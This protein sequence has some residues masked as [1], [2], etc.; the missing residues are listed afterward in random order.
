MTDPR[1]NV[2][3]ILLEQWRGDCIGV[4]E[5]APHVIQTPNIDFIAREGIRFSRAYAE[6]PTCAPARRCII[7]GTSPAANGATGF[8]FAPWNPAHTMP[9][10]LAAHGYQ[11][12]MIGKLHLHPKR[13]RFG[14]HHMRLAD[15]LRGSPE[16]NDYVD[17]LQR[18]HGRWEN[19]IAKAHGVGSNSFVG[20]PS[21]L[22]EEQM[23]GFW[24]VDEAIDFL[25]RRDPASPSFLNL[26]FFEAHPPFC[27]PPLYY[28]RYIAM[29]LPQPVVGDWAPHVPHTTGFDPARVEPI[30]LNPQMM[31]QCR[32][33]YYGLINFVDDQIGRLYE[34]NRRLF[35]ESLVVIAADHGES[36]GDHHR[37]AKLHPHEGSARVPLIVRPPR[38]WDMPRGRVCDTPVGLQD[39]MPTILD[40]VGAPVP[41]TC[42]GHSLMPIVRG[43][44]DRVRDVLHGEHSSTQVQQLGHHYLV[45]D[46]H[47]YVW[48]TQSGR[49]LF[50][51][52]RA[53]PHELHDL[54]PE[55]DLDPW[56]ARLVRMLRD[57]PEGF[58]DGRR[59]IPGRPECDLIPGYDPDRTLSF[60]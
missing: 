55:A 46:G 48:F 16:I 2:I 10:D 17:W 57:R 25:K 15:G 6:A 58:T 22:P 31:R 30:R 44:T 28:N 19:D 11:T 20:R 12:E 41:E 29:D 26:S 53:D 27:P 9:G 59:L 13:K 38:H 45:G 24:V 60:L 42:T 40:A 34:Y 3:F 54:A 35:D 37:I 52:L 18:K 14:F 43:A 4:D 7:S 1:P 47:K 23:Y 51:D 21:N 50:F 33:G 32:A 39:L 49:E 8:T 5:H 36:L 56:R